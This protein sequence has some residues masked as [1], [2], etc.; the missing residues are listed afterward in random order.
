MSYAFTAYILFSSCFQGRFGTGWARVAT[1]YQANIPWVLGRLGLAGIQSAVP[2]PVVAV[3]IIVWWPIWVGRCFSSGSSGVVTMLLS[4]LSDDSWAMITP[5]IYWSK[6]WGPP[7]IWQK[8]QSYFTEHYQYCTS[9]LALL[10]W[11]CCDCRYRSVCQTLFRTY[12]KFLHIHES[13]R[14][15]FTPVQQV[16]AAPWL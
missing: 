16:I 3:V 6:Q 1:N 14:N 4:T 7:S 2:V 10:R 12:T 15:S 8:F 5:P 9:D 13:Q 11:D